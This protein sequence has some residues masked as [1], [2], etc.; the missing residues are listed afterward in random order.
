MSTSNISQDHHV[1][2]I[3]ILMMYRMWMI[4]QFYGFIWKNLRTYIVGGGSYES[5][6]ASLAK[7]HTD[8][9]SESFVEGLRELKRMRM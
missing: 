9:Y 4:R 2:D 5:L 3:Q 6:N 7:P 8:S 1:G